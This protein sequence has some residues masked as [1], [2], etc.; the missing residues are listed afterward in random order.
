MGPAVC[1]LW[2][3]GAHTG[4]QVGLRTQENRERPGERDPRAAG[5]AIARWPQPSPVNCRLSG[6]S[7]RPERVRSAPALDT[8]PCQTEPLGPA[9]AS[10]SP[11]RAQPEPSPSPT[12]AQLGPARLGS[13]AQLGSARSRAILQPAQ[14][15][16]GRS[17]ADY[18]GILVRDLKAAA[19]LVDGVR[20]HLCCTSR[21][22]PLHNPHHPPRSHV[23][24]ERC[25]RVTVPEPV[26]RRAPGPCGVPP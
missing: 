3:L 21:R 22:G 4:D 18:A 9:Q 20:Q 16:S 10:P 26:S 14:R 11:A 6:H 2:A 1:L 15:D 24:Y 25:D 5:D 12:R 8:A 13:S 17:G 7:P 19:G 23:V